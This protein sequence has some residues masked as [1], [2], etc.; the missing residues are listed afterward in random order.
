MAEL[1]RRYKKHEKAPKVIFNFSKALKFN[2]STY[3]YMPRKE[4]VRKF[5]GMKLLCQDDR[6][7]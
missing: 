3:V 6:T 4:V 2:S 1:Q 5:H 7:L